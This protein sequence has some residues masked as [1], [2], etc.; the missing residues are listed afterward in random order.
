METMRL[1][2]AL[3]AKTQEERLAALRE[4]KKLHDNGA[5]PPAAA[6][7]YVNN[8]IHTTYS[9]SP[10]SPTKA[11]Y[12]AWMNGLVT[13][14]IMDHDSVAGA[15]EF[16]EA[17]KIVGIATTVALECRISF[18]DTP[19]CG[20]RLNN[21]DQRTVAYAGL[22][23]IP[24]QNL[25]RVQAFMAPLR[26]KRNVRNRKM[27]ENL[28]R[29]LA[30]KGVS[31]D[32]DRDVLPLSEAKNGGA[33]TERHLLYA[34]SRKM[35]EKAGT[36]EP[37]L[38]F[39]QT[40]FGI[41]PSGKNRSLLLDPENPF[42]AY[43]LLG[44]LKANLVEQ[45]Y[46][47]ADEECASIDAF[48]GLARETGAIAAYAYLGDVTD[49]VTGDK[50]AQT[51]EDA[52]LDDLIPE[53][54]RRGFQAI[55][56]SPTRNTFGQIERLH[57]LC[58]D[59]NLFEVSGEDINS[60][61]QSFKNDMVLS[62][63]YSRLVTSTWALIGHEIAGTACLSDSM[64]SAETETRYPRMQDRVSHYYAIGIQSSETD[65]C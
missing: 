63:K 58:E 11:V 24:H 36:G 64:F 55:T 46:V 18:A 44:V 54:R 27:V 35:I 2:D 30:G 25:A 26:E 7:K 38:Q 22:H 53:V 14:G 9:F 62:E 13:A 43:D 23:G 56:Y 49:S 51:F 34:L 41:A 28:N 4:L 47:D 50:K 6:G 40:S 45:F 42:C 1:L 5:L 19:F 17:G 33:V 8:H 60:P 59:N 29:L 31:L 61:R 21:P 16:I 20:R 48:I 3:N 37:L 52:F 65:K 57:R 32:F 10:Y 15:E 39:L 12:T